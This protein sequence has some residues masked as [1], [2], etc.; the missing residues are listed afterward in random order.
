MPGSQ[1]G[2]LPVELRPHKPRRESNPPLRLCKP[3]PRRSATG[4]NCLSRTAA[5]RAGIEP[6]ASRFGAG[7]SSTVELRARPLETVNM[8]REGLEP[9][10]GHWPSALQADAIAALPPARDCQTTNSQ[11]D[12][13]RTG[14]LV[15]PR[16]VLCQVELHPNHANPCSRGDSNPPFSG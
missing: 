10:V 16:H 3:A 9:P 8:R 5:R 14:N 13:I 15:R 7:H 12:R 4:L 11:G 2:A 6:A 1:P